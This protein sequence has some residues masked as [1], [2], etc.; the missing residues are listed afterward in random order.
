MAS[1]HLQGDYVVLASEPLCLVGIDVAAPPEARV[2]RAQPTS[3]LF[4]T[5]KDHMT[6]AEVH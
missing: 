6:L 3:E 5:F 1:A 4:K 2:T